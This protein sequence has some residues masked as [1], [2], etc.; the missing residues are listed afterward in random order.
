MFLQAACHANDEAPCFIEQAQSDL[1]EE[2]EGEY[3]EIRHGAWEVRLVLDETLCAATCFESALVE[4]DV[5]ITCCHCEDCEMMVVGWVLVGDVMFTFLSFS[6]HAKC[7]VAKCFHVK[8]TREGAALLCYVCC[9]Q[10]DHDD[11][12]HLLASQ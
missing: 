9:G 10:G 3:D 7:R 1:S 12:C 11:V 6:F 2:E 5:V 8:S 4:S